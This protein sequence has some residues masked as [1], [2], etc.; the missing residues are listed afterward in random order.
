[1]FSSL[2]ERCGSLVRS[3]TLGC[4]LLSA[5]G[6]NVCCAQTR[7]G[8]DSLAPPPNAD[9][10]HPGAL[11]ARVTALRRQVAAEPGNLGAQLDLGIALC[12]LGQGDDAMRTFL[13]L[14]ARADLPPAIAEVISWYRT[15]GCRASTPARYGGGFV[16]LGMGWARNFNLAPLAESIYLPALDAQ[17]ALDESSRRRNASLASLE[18]GVVLPLT[19]DQRWSLGA[20]LNALRYQGSPDYAFTGVQGSLNWRAQEGPR[21]SEMQASLGA[22]KV[23][24]TTRI[25]TATLVGSRLLEI[26][27]GWWSGGTL[28]ATKIDYYEQAALDAKQYELRG[29]LRWQGS[30]TRFTADLGWME[31]Q[32]GSERPGGNRRGPVV[33][34]HLLWALPHG[35][36]LEATL[37]H[38]WLRD[39]AAYSPA[40]FG[41]QHRKPRVTMASLAIRQ[42]L[43]QS[44]AAKL[45]LRATHSRDT[46]ELFK[47]GTQSAWASLEWT[48]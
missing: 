45:E 27:P 46:L 28:S 4:I 10:A 30:Q 1:M 6:S 5:L 33:Q 15:G 25:R 11:R 35:R 21:V 40:L 36:S 43:T 16:A 38:S 26:G 18:A 37:K 31:D 3:A 23:G 29:R 14:E 8:D 34:S 20:Y 44:L 12:L 41:E 19:A 24:D 2:A 42:P 47:Y 13:L 32:Q 22:L 39:S 7:G 17:L 9:E 48:P